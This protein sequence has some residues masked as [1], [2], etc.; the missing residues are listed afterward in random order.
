MRAFF[1]GWGFSS[2]LKLMTGFSEPFG[3][4]VCLLSFFHYSEF[5]ITSYISP[6][7]LSLDSFLLNHSK[8][9]GI[10]AL[11][12]VIEFQLEIYAVPCE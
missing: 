5:L 9:Y 2:G 7:T 12:S 11:A 6:E 3:L 10:A 1:L 8:E 4:Y